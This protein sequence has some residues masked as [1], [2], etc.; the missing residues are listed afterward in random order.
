MQMRIRVL[1]VLV[2]LAAGAWFSHARVENAV[3]PAMALDGFPPVLGEW[4]SVGQVAFDGATLA[5]LR[6]TDYLLRL[7]ANGAGRRIGLY[8]G[9]HGGG[10]NAGAIHSP[11]NCLPGAGWMQLDSA[12]MD[13]PTPEGVVRLARATYAKGAEG[14]IY[15]YWYQV[16]GETLADD[17]DLKLAELRNAVL[18]GRRDA[19][20]VRLDVPVEQAEGA[21]ADVSAFVARLYPLLRQYLPR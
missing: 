5:V 7:Y 1:V 21:D 3:P 17:L 16:R 14:S 19:A 15:Y 4:R 11:R 10:R 12:R 20:F 13:V 18:D 2:F 9:Y 8:V 6:P